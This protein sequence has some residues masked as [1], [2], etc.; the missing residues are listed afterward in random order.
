MKLKAIKPNDYTNYHDPEG[1]S[2]LFVGMGV[3]DWKCCIAANI[4][5]ETCQN[6]ELAKAPVVEMDAETLIRTYIGESGS[7]VVGGLEPF[8]DMASLKELAK[9][10]SETVSYLGENTQFDKFVVY[11]G[12]KPDEIITLVEQIYDIV[13]TKLT[14]IVKFGRFVPNQTPHFDDVLGVD[15]ASDNQ[16]A[17]EITKEFIE[18]VRKNTERK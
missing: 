11:T 1:W 15:L 16:Y 5:I 6:S 17:K 7:V 4:P 8:N 18:H 2:S 12:Y 9:A 14:F 13:K 10:Y 3:C